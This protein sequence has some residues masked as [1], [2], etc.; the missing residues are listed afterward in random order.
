MSISNL[1][2]K[3]DKLFSGYLPNCVIKVFYKNNMSIMYLYSIYWWFFSKLYNWKVN[4]VKIINEIKRCNNYL[5]KSLFSLTTL[6][7]HHQ[8]QS[9]N[10][11]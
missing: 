5:I 11:I 1:F 2:I 6:L 10:I 9:I 3:G 7:Y 4:F 8:Q